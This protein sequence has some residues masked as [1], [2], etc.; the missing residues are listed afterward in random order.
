M[1]DIVLVIGGTAGIGLATAR[2]LKE[3]GYSVIVAGRRKINL[4]DVCSLHIDV[5]EETS[6]VELRN[7]IED[8][9]G[10]ISSLV[11]STG[12]T[13]PKKSILD[14]QKEQWQ[15]VVDVNVTGLIL[16]LKIFYPHLVEMQGRVA[17]VSSV[18]AR[19]Y[20]QFSSFEYTASKA[21]IGGI[22]RQLSQEWARDK[23]LINSVFPS[24]T[25][26][27]MLENVLNPK[28]LEALASKSVLGKIADTL[29]TSRAIE[30]LIS[31]KNQYTTGSGIDVSGGAYLN[32]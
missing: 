30:F 12:K 5:C 14:F 17:V 4:E 28:E 2:Y 27:E 1:S 15:E 3:K 8:R 19:T 31:K 21:A 11:Y 7:E 9:F 20:S 22:V 29:D 18:A 26:T 32:A 23:I 6:I 13:V 10:K 25:K 16:T 24:M